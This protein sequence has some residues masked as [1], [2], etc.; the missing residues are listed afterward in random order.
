MK[1]IKRKIINFLKFI[2]FRVNYKDFDGN[3][4]RCRLNVFEV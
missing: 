3:F 4:T 1:R 2:D